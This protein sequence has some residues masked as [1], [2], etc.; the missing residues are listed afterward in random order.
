MKSQKVLVVGG[1]GYI[2]GAVVDHLLEK[3]I[4]VLVYDALVYE[5]DYRKNVKFMFGDVL[6]TERLGSV[7]ASFQP[8]S[9]IWLAAIVGDGA[10]AANAELAIQVNEESVKWLADH[11]QKR[12]VFTSTCSVYGRNNELLDENAQKN[13]LSL[14]ASTKLKA[15][16]HLK[17][18]ESVIFRLGTL[19]G[20]SDQFSRIRMDLVVNVLSLKAMMGEDFKVFGGEQWRPLLHVKDAAIAVAHAAIETEDKQLL[21]AGTYNLAQSNMTIRDLA[22]KIKRVSIANKPITIHYLDLQFE[23]Q[24]NYRVSAAH[25]ESSNAPVR[26]SRSVEDGALEIM[27]LIKQGR[28][29]NPYSPIFHN[30]RYIEEVAKN[31]RA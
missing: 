4:D 31:G 13:P 29:K 19:H 14:Y 10:C 12:I 3:H 27:T 22:E 5:R 26:F 21:V 8:D 15:E 2:G 9:I 18:R 30:Q 24:R 1:A 16:D 23:D 11:F 7:L 17:D 25:Y 6:D 20:V 28:I